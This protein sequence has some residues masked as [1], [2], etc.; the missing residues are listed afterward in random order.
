[1][2]IFIRLFN[3]SLNEYFTLSLDQL[4]INAN[5]ITEKKLLLD[6]NTFFLVSVMLC[7]PNISERY[8]FQNVNREYHFS[9]I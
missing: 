2:K 9:R 4:I 1:M 3:S 5:K 7:M 8:R 6:N